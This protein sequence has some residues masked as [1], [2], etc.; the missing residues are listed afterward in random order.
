MHIPSLGRVQ[1]GVS[2]LLSALLVTGCGASPGGEDERASAS[3]AAL[4]H[5]NDWGFWPT[6]DITVCWDA[7]EWN[8]SSLATFR[9][10]MRTWIEQDVGRI[11]DLRFHGWGQ[12]PTFNWNGSTW[13]N[14][15][16]MIAI[17]TITTTTWS[18]GGYNEHSSHWGY[19]S[20]GPTRVEFGTNAVGG[21]GKK[22][23]EGRILHEF[24]HALGFGHEFNRPDNTAK[25][26]NWQDS[27]P[28]NNYGTPYD[29]DSIMNN[30]YCGW[31]RDSLSAWDT[32]GLQRAY[33]PK[34]FGSIVGIANKCLDLAN[35]AGTTPTAA[36][37][38]QAYECYGNSNQRW[39]RSNA[40]SL[41]AEDYVWANSS[42]YS[43]I[44][45][46][47]GNSADGTQLWNWQY[48]G[49]GAQLWYFQTMALVGMGGLCLDVP[50]ASYYA[51]APL[52]VWTCNGG[53]NQQWS[54]VK[55]PN[56]STYLSSVGAPN[57]CI[58]GTGASDLTLQPCHFPG[59]NGAVDWT[60]AFNM[61]GSEI[62]LL[63]AADDCFD[64][65][66]AVP[67]VGT[68]VGRY[69]CRTLEDPLQYAQRWYAR[70]PI[71][72]LAGKCIDIDI[73]HGHVD[74]GTRVQLY[75]CWGG[76]NQTYDF[77]F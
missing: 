65:S 77:H 38:I 29:P 20:S 71:T 28:G 74:N 14:G 52:Q 55:Q 18:K 58:T 66:G 11:T 19:Q 26:C 75:S 39:V 32:V 70:G 25:Q 36:S 72:G 21:S 69:P 61:A 63:D 1:L 50:G 45:V 49:G 73:G 22:G 3:E 12:C 8:D 56:G 2:C 44:D 23:S 6:H 43:Y 53:A 64:V 51:G 34:P 37:S 13:T 40:A 7:A 24:L 10:N 31:T 54:L 33:G 4:N 46:Q 30:T 27:E 42:S 76:T 67:A 15:T 68:H 48:N 9:E 60:Q 17:H 47:W 35:G 16:G 62:S 5:P 41:V 57:L 59:A